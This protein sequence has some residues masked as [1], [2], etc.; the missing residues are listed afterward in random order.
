MDLRYNQKLKPNSFLHQSTLS[1]L[2]TKPITFKPLI[3]ASWPTIEPTAP[4]AAVTRN[5]S[6]GFGLH[7]FK[8]INAVALNYFINKNYFY[9]N[10]LNKIIKFEPWHSKGA[11][12]IR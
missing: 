12:C 3:L 2:P 8:P 11:Q 7:L 10:R 6:P 4:A 1:S 9:L 5:V